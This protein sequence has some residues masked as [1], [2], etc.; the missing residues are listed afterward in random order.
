[1][2]TLFHRLVNIG[3]QGFDAFELMSVAIKSFPDYYRKLVLCESIRSMPTGDDIPPTICP[4]AVITD[5]R[6]LCLSVL[7]AVY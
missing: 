4:T 1:M 2:P 6:F 7:D 5:V 3:G